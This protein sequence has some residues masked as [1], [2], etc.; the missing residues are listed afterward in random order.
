VKENTRESYRKLSLKPLRHSKLVTRH[1]ASPNDPK[2]YYKLN[3][4]LAEVI[5]NGP[6]S[7]WKRKVKRLAD[8]DQE[9]ERVLQAGGELRLK[10]QSGRLIRLSAG[11]HNRLALMFAEHFPKQHRPAAQVAFIGD[12]A[13]RRGYQDRDLLRE[14]NLT[15]DVIQTVPDGIL[16]DTAGKVLV[17]AEFVTSVGAIS[18]SRKEDLERKLSPARELG[19]SIKYLTV[20]PDR[21]TFARFAAQIAYG[22]FVWIAEEPEHLIRYNGP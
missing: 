6:G 1:Q 20:F 5:R 2:T 22:T 9:K 21:K 10:L 3:T 14:V 17:V 4:A 18:Q 16:L 15:L 13:N 7:N 12:Q 8:L 11:E 19:Y